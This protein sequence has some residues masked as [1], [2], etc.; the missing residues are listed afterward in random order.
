MKK[1]APIGMFALVMFALV[2][3][4]FLVKLLDTVVQKVGESWT[5]TNTNMVILAVLGLIAAP[6]LSMMSNGPAGSSSRSSSAPNYKLL[7]DNG[8]QKPM[9]YLTD[10]QTTEAEWAPAQPQYN[11]NFF[12]E[13]VDL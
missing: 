8:Q 7:A 2:V 10:S 9:G 5:G 6:L 11:D 4:V 12:G 1:M 3:G 13:D